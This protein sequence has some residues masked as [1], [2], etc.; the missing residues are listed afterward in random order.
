MKD[1][2]WAAHLAQTLSLSSFNRGV[3]HVL[4]VMCN[5]YV[6]QYACVKP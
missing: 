2:V 5:R 1:N 4:C 6:H 3:K